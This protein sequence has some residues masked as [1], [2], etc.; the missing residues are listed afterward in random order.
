V[1]VAVIEQLL[2]VRWATTPSSVIA[3][4]RISFRNETSPLLALAG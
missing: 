4:S 2:A 3:R 1:A